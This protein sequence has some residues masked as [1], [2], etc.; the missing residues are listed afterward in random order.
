[1]DIDYSADDPS[2]DNAYA[3]TEGPQKRRRLETALDTSPEMN[4]VSR[5]P[6]SPQRRSMFTPTGSESSVETKSNV[7]DVQDGSVLPVVGA[8]DLSH[9]NVSFEEPL[10]DNERDLQSTLEKLRQQCSRVEQRLQTCRGTRPRSTAS[11]TVFVDLTEGPD[12]IDDDSV[13]SEP[14]AGYA[15][16]TSALV[17]QMGEEN[18]DLRTKLSEQYEEL[19]EI[20]EISDSRLKELQDHQHTSS[21]A[22]TYSP[23]D[24]IG[25]VEALNNGIESF[26]LYANGV[27]YFLP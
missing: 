8:E 11:E 10:P 3:D 15:H 9:T 27:G 25:A 24:C 5:T 4:D 6:Q 2:L 26:C 20:K 18:Q 13:S 17:R 22:D 14:L 12:A 1:V 16:P 23:S 7:S 21:R 19:R